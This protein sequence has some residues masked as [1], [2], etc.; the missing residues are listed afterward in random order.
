[1][2]TFSENSFYGI[3][4]SEVG[5]V[6]DGVGG[7][8]FL[9]PGMALDKGLPIASESIHLDKIQYAHKNAIRPEF[10]SKIIY[11]KAS[12]W[13]N[14]ISLSVSSSINNYFN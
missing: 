7:C 3:K 13:R 11:S 2:K 10:Q 12:A 9:T 4:L 1:M 6:W 8:P 5:R 14:R